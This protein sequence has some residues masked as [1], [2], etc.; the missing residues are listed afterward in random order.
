MHI[1]FPRLMPTVSSPLVPQGGDLAESSL[2]MPP[3]CLALAGGDFQNSLSRKVESAVPSSLILK[4]PAR[5][6]ASREALLRLLEAVF[7]GRAQR[8]AEPRAHAAEVS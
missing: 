3:R 7:D 5:P 1:H 2:Q 6:D 8:C 4:K